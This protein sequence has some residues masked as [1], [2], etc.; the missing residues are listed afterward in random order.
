MSDALPLWPPKCDRNLPRG[1]PRKGI[2]NA[3]VHY[4]DENGTYSPYF[5]G[6]GFTAQDLFDVL[7]VSPMDPVLIKNEST[8]VF[9]GTDVTIKLYG[10]VPHPNDSAHLYVGKLSDAFA[11]C[12]CTFS[13]DVLIC[14]KQ[15]RMIINDVDFATAYEGIVMSKEAGYNPAKH[16]S[17]RR[18]CTDSSAA[19]SSLV[20]MA[21]P[22][23]A[24]VSVAQLQQA[25]L[26][27]REQQKAQLAALQQLQ[28]AQQAAIQKQQALQQQQAAQLATKQVAAFFI[29]FVKGTCSSMLNLVPNQSMFIIDMFE[30]LF[31]VFPAAKT[32]AKTFWEKCFGGE[33]FQGLYDYVQK[34]T[35]DPGINNT[36]MKVFEA[37]KSDT[38]KLVCLYDCRPL[39][40]FAT[41]L[42][43]LIVAKPDPV[44]PFDKKK[45]IND[46]YA[47]AIVKAK[48]AKR[49]EMIQAMFN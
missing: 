2:V 16:S 7:N 11:M 5:P 1:D 21:A 27:A 43:L 12:V 15:V 36:V 19:A 25:A 48:K 34:Y 44:A 29:P 3:C 14:G 23:A 4:G 10:W 45:E 20:A 8:G 24:D 41:R 46:R 17:K 37:M 47:E 9:E 35:Q 49:D 22:A 38:L 26:Q 40:E 33:M 42:C 30:A 18:K 32:N 31:V 28:A 39:V 13:Q 6:F